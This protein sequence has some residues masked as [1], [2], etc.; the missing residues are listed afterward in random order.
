MRTFDLDSLPQDW[1]HALSARKFNIL[2]T[3]LFDRRISGK[4]E[5]LSGGLASQII[6]PKPYKARKRL[7]VLNTR[8]YIEGSALDLLEDQ[9]KS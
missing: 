5:Y 1:T 6:I 8:I 2:F 3:K 9:V 4:L 7:Q